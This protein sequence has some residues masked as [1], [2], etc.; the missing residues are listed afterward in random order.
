MRKILEILRLKWGCGLSRDSVARSC[1]LSGSTVSEYL[2]RAQRAGL[3]WPLPESIGEE[4]LDQLLFP[5]SHRRQRV[6]RP[7]PNWNQ[8]HGDLVT[9]KG[10][11]LQLLWEEYRESEPEGYAYTQFCEYYKRWV[12][13]LNPVLRLNHK[14]GEKCFVDY[15]GTKLSVVDRETGEI[16]DAELFV[17]VLG[18][19]SL[20]YAEAH[21]GQTL[22][23]WIG[24]HVRMFQEFGGVSQV[25][26][27]DNLKSGV[28][29]PCRYEPDINPTYHD[30]A[31]QY[32]IA[33][34]P[35]GSRKPKHK[36]K[37][38]NGVLVGLRWIIA[39]LRN[40][41][42][43]SLPELNAAIREQ[44]VAINNRTMRGIGKSRRELFEEIDKPALRPLPQVPYEFAVWKHAK[45]GIDYHAQF[46]GYF[47]SVPFTLLKQPVLVRATERTVEILHKG[48]RVASHMRQYG[49]DRYCTLREHR[50]PSHK[51]YLD[52]SPDRFARWAD[53][54]GPRTRQ[55][56]DARLA[57]RMHPEQSFRLCLGILKLAEKY[58]PERLEAACAKALTVGI[59]SYKRIREM[60]ANGRE[61]ADP[62][63][64]TLTLAPMAAHVNVRGTTYYQ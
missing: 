30:F 27:P 3:S 31:N 24:A 39:R 51:A 33:V 45:I 26:V 25:L 44:V 32:G 37:V 4:E 42:F 36:A 54:I 13:K 23:H 22:P 41:T 56:I 53:R 47:Y 1:N 60:L 62:Q 35:A 49:K 9:G 7:L 46:D 5:D 50:P 55:Y 28:T 64:Q 10:V 11:T 61:N 58:S 57:S 63:Q 38:E 17:G 15:S 20:L 34:V 14:A 52:W 19:S 6:G 8:V 43:F 2:H 21:W 16:Q 40:R 29:N 12:G 18:V 59:T 48:N